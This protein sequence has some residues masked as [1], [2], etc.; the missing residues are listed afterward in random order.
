MCT[1]T[2][3]TPAVFTHG[4]APGCLRFCETNN[5]LYERQSGCAPVHTLFALFYTCTGARALLRGHYA[6]LIRPTLVKKQPGLC[7][8]CGGCALFAAGRYRGWANEAVCCLVRPLRVAAPVAV[9]AEP[10]E[11]VSTQCWRRAAPQQ[12]RPAQVPAG[13]QARLA[14]LAPAN[15]LATLAPAMTTPPGMQHRC[16]KISYGSPKTASSPCKEFTTSWHSESAPWSA[17]CTH[18]RRFASLVG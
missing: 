16:C 7:K 17:L 9:P 2:G 18:R 11:W 1:G 15:Y 5:R 12:R 13:R 4:A 14:I 10:A 8:R 6:R 3:T